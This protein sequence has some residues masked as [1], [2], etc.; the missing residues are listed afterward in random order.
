MAHRDKRIIL[1]AACLLLI[2][3]NALVHVDFS[4][5]ALGCSGST[6]KTGASP[7]TGQ[8]FRQ[9]S[10]QFPSHFSS[11]KRAPAGG[12]FRSYESHTLAAGST[13]FFDETLL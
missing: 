11:T 1:A 2:I 4:K 3:M 9:V 5:T 7:F 12:N 10:D 6:P 8:I 13:S